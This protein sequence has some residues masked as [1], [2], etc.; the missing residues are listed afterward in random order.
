MIILVIVLRSVHGNPVATYVSSYHRISRIFIIAPMPSDRIYQQHFIVNVIIFL[1]V[2]GAEIPL[3]KPYPYS[4]SAHPVGGVPYGTMAAITTPPVIHPPTTS[5]PA[6]SPTTRIQTTPL[7]KAVHQSSLS[8][9]VATVATQQPK[10]K[11]T[12]PAFKTPSKKIKSPKTVKA[13]TTVSSVPESSRHR[14]DNGSKETQNTKRDVDKTKHA[15]AQQS[16]PLGTK[17]TKLNADDTSQKKVMPPTT[18]STT[19]DVAAATHVDATKAE[20]QPAPDHTDYEATK[21]SQKSTPK[22]TKPATADDPKTSGFANKGKGSNRENT[23]SKADSSDH[24]KSKNKGKNQTTPAKGKGSNRENTASKTDSSELFKSKTKAKTQ[25]TPA[26]KGKGGNREGTASKA[27]PSEHSKSKNKGKN[28][29]SPVNKGKGSNR[30]NRAKNQ[31][32]Q[33]NVNKVCLSC[34]SLLIK[35]RQV[36]K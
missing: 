27:D 24:S 29:T 20:L 22:K 8:A 35:Y 1:L 6:T 10:P 25:T 2:Q 16:V 28:Q 21:E 7:P 18:P 14:Q 36:L 12:T 30:E 4:Y 11:P 31:T 23:A 3:Y 34:L 13:G 19:K 26:N 15:D 5:V 9:R 33:H 17:K 32:T